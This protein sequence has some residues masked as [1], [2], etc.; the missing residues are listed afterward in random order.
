MCR[1]KKIH[2]VLTA[3]MKTRENIYVECRH[4]RY[5][6]QQILDNGNRIWYTRVKPSD[7]ENKGDSLKSG[8]DRSDMLRYDD[9]N[10]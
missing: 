4:D 7:L 1:G 10:K 2:Q 8:S 3:Q 5:I 9:V 6:I